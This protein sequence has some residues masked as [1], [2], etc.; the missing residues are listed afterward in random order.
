M[1]A[2]SSPQIPADPHPAHRLKLGNIRRA[3]EVIDPVFLSSPQYGCEAVSEAIGCALTL[4]LETANPIRS[5]KGR[6]ASF[7]IAERLRRGE[8]GGRALVGASAGN[9]GQALAYAC[10]SRGLPLI[11]YAATRANPLKVERMRA[12]GA[13]VR[14]AG[15]DFDA[16]KQAAEAFAAETGAMMLAD[17]LDPEA[18]EGA[19]T[20]ALELMAGPTPPDCIVVPLGNGAMLTGIARWA[21]AVKPAVEIIGVQATGADAMEKSWRTGTLVFPPTVATIAD[22]I[23]VRVPIAEAVEDMKG[24]VDDVH[25]VEDAAL[26]EAMRLFHGRAGLVAEPSGAAGLA[27]ILS[28]PELFRGRRVATILCGGNL[29]AE[30][31]RTWLG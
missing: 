14:L 6:G 2:H 13:E 25:L 12:L 11:L 28:R 7:L 1:T 30:Q 20:I 10:R 31:M 26:I 16:A 22:G 23:G 29:T 24:L 21:K 18:S 4:K 8:I 17:G 5:F 19:G 3:I 15:D 27:A 9:W